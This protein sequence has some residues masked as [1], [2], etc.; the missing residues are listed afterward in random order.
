MPAVIAAV[1]RADGVWSGAAG[2]DGPEG[3]PAAV[4]DE[5]AMAG[6]TKV[7]T[8]ALV[9][10]LAETGELQLDD[11]LSSYLPDDLDSNGATVL[12]ALQMRSGIPDTQ[13]SSRA[14]LSAEPSR[15][16]T[17]AELTA[18]LPLPT[19]PAG[20]EYIPSDPT[21]TML[22]L[23][24]ETATGLPLADAIRSLLLNPAGSSTSLLLQGAATPTP[25]PWA[26]PISDTDAPITTFGAGSALPNLADATS[27][28]GASGMAGTA[29][30]LADWA[31]Q[32][33]AGKIVSTTSVNR[34]ITGEDGRAGFGLDDLSDHDLPGAFGRI[35]S[36]DGYES[37][38][39][40][41]PDDH[42]VIVVF[43]TQRDSAVESVAA[44]LDE[45]LDP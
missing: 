14:K 15:S 36:A 39:A 44:S 12:Q 18:A 13:S 32:L 21:Y 42:T 5:F 22:G 1:I 8:A 33:F 20:T 7:F 31:W 45:A 9:M 3:R 41:Y 40:V 17:R 38:L 4:H 28:A 34:L 30:D 19:A 27:T 25:R 37:V 16:W 23:A 6:I 43:A 26:L 29:P 11:P 35:G 24:A 2:T 10:R